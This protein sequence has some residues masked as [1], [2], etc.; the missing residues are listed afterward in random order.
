MAEDPAFNAKRYRFA[1]DYDPYSSGDTT[2]WSTVVNDVDIDELLRKP[3][4]NEEIHSPRRRCWD[5]HPCGRYND[6]VRQE[7]AQINREYSRQDENR[8]PL[9]RV[10]GS[11]G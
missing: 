7:R 9:Y 6:E 4:S 2:Q 8:N 1:D 10:L 3:F 11:R 5:Y